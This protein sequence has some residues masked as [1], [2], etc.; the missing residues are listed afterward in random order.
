MEAIDKCQ[1]KMRFRTDM[2]AAAA[3][4]KKQFKY[5]KSYRWYRCGVCLGYHLTSRPYDEKFEAQNRKVKAFVRA[6]GANLY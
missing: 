3:A 1:G 6:I 2:D 5:G 4:G